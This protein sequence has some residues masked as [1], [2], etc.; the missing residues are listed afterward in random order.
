MAALAGGCTPSVCGGRSRSSLGL[1][2][3]HDDV[4]RQFRRGTCF[5]ERVDRIGKSTGW[6]GGWS[7]FMIPGASE[8]RQIPLYTG[9]FY[10]YCAVGGILSCGI[11]HTGVTPL[12][13]VKCNMQVRA[14][15]PFRILFSSI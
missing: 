9:E 11:T 15:V 8:T 6:D 7:K 14:S 3:V 1:G 4:L 5:D 13:I 12:D 10:A 2:R